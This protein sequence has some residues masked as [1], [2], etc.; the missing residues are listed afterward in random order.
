[1]IS[2]HAAV[3]LFAPQPSA[4]SSAHLITWETGGGKRVSGLRQAIFSKDRIKVFLTHSHAYV[5][6]EV[7]SDTILDTP[8]HSTHSDLVLLPQACARREIQPQQR[9]E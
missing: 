5:L 2:L 4:S 8:A 3:D 7:L 1:M 6:A 9:E